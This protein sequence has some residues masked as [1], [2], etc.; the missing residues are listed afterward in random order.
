MADARSLVIAKEDCSKTQRKST[1]NKQTY[2]AT[3]LS[4][5]KGLLGVIC[6]NGIGLT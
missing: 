3:Y 1:G 4:D 5:G 6:N 2:I